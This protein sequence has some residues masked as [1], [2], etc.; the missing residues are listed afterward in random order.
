MSATG[1]CRIVGVVYTGQHSCASH[2][3]YSG[4]APSSLPGVPC[5]V[6]WCL[7]FAF[8]LGDTF[9]SSQLGGHAILASPPLGH[10]SFAL[11]DFHSARV[12]ME[13]WLRS[14][15]LYFE[16]ARI[17]YEFILSQAVSLILWTFIRKKK[18]ETGGLPFSLL[19]TCLKF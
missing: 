10:C 18:E 19:I 12:S 17:F 15:S 13:T 7:G 3:T 1:F 11:C 16:S 6:L 14:F 8:S 2:Q 4:G 5:W 9:V